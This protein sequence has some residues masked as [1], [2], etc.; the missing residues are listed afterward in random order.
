LLPC[1]ISVKRTLLF[2]GEMA[3]FLVAFHFPTL[4]SH[5]RKVELSI[6]LLFFCET[7]VCDRQTDGQ[8]DRRHSNRQNIRRSIYRPFE[9]NFV[10]VCRTPRAF[11]VQSMASDQHA[12]HINNHDAELI[13][14]LTKHRRRSVEPKLVCVR[15]PSGILSAFAG[16]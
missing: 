16:V 9:S 5:A 10:R 8:M 7:H 2:L 15:A 4:H 3:D 11:T 12:G 6:I 1:T 13:S 14:Q